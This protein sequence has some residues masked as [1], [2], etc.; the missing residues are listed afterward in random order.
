M[1]VVE[2]PILQSPKHFQP[3]QLAGAVLEEHACDAFV[4]LV[5]AC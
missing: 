5:L 1:Q 2:D 3:W 4:L